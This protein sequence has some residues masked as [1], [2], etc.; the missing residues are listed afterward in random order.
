MVVAALFILSF[1]GGFF[2]RMGVWRSNITR[3]AEQSQPLVDAITAYCTEHGHPPDSLSELVPDH[4]ARIPGTGI[5]AWPEYQYLA[6]QQATRY[7]GNEWVLLVTPPNLPMGF[8]V[9]MYF[10]RQNYP[11]E[12]YGGGI[13]RIGGWGYVHE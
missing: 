12:G 11:R 7:D 4:I 2:W 1:F 8:D 9:F 3:V 6:G 10:P 5:G 13:E